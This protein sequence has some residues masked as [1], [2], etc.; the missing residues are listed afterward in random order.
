MDISTQGL[1]DH[2]F[3]YIEDSRGQLAGGSTVARGFARLLRQ[4]NNLIFNGVR[5]YSALSVGMNDCVLGF[6]SEQMTLSWI[7][8]H[9]LTHVSMPA[10]CN[11]IS[12]SS[13]PPP[14]QKHDNAFAVP[15][16]FNY[17][18]V[19]AIYWRTLSDK[20]S[21]RTKLLLVGIQHTL[22]PWK[23]HTEAEK[24][25]FARAR[26]W[27]DAL[28][29]D[30]E[31]MLVWLVE[32]RY[33]GDLLNE[34]VDE[35]APEEFAER[36][37]VAKKAQAAEDAKQEEKGGRVR[38]IAIPTHPTPKFTRHVIEIKEIADRI[39]RKLAIAR[40]ET[41]SPPAV[42][43]APT[44]KARSSAAPGKKAAKRQKTERKPSISKPSAPS[45]PPPSQKRRRSDSEDS[46]SALSS[47]IHISS[48]NEND[49]DGEFAAPKTRAP[50][51]APPAQADRRPTRG[52]PDALVPGLPY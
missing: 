39:G 45:K 25:F 36:V 48:G 13:D 51:A 37:R 34:E 19:D 8:I 6:L 1:F 18:N 10:G 31:F 14:I 47:A 11:T 46:S 49:D 9:G 21:P 22:S 24:P 35:E 26:A 7:S 32:K 30:V 2:R 12:F 52:N 27:M 23:K 28:N 29:W 50:T 16:A 15:L 33:D 44:V 3:Q 5:W 38:T 20:H 43:K 17:P 41:Y 4:S 40:G 42:M